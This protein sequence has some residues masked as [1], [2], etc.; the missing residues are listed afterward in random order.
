MPRLLELCSG[1]GSVG[2]AFAALGWDVVSVDIDR[3]ARPTICCSVLDLTLE[4]CHERGPID[5]VW[6]SPPC[7]HY[8]CLRARWGPRDLEGSDRIV[9][10][11]LRIARE[12]NAPLI[13]ENPHSGL[14]K[15]RPVML[16][17]RMPMSVVDY[18]KYGAP[19]R[20]RTALWSNC[21]FVPARPLCRHDCA[22]SEGRRHPVHAQW[23]NRAGGRPVRRHVLY[24]LPPELTAEIA[25]FAHSRH[26]SSQARSSSESSVS[27]TI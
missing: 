9:A 3:K 25:A 22:A 20:K 26:C 27:A 21:G 7:C 6:A 8:S 15:T 4:Q 2:R 14:L 19:Y 23:G 10:A 13:M 11:C 24:A 12:L 1:T 16:E 5:F 18:C 17:A